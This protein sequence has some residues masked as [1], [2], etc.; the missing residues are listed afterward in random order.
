MGAMGKTTLTLKAMN[1]LDANYISDDMI[2]INE[3]G[4]ILTYPNRIKL[5]KFGVS[6][7][8]IEQYVDPVEFF[9]RYKFFRD[10]GQFCSNEIINNI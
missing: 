1:L 6:P 4:D 3:Y 10:F 5:R 2:I 9:S 7:I 8:S